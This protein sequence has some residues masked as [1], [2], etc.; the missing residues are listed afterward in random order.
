[1]TL[2]IYDDSTGGISKWTET[3]PTVLLVDDLF[4]VAG[5]ANNN[6]AVNILDVTYEINFLY[7]DGDPPDCADEA[8]ANGN[9]A[10]NILDV[11]H[12]IN[13]LYKEGSAPVCGTTGS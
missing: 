10:I 3:R 7:K 1:M 5:N 9:N 2:T 6:G 4:D 11:T 12:L 13:Y 8:D